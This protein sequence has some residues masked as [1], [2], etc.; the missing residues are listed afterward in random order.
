MKFKKDDLKLIVKDLV[1]ESLLE[2]LAEEYIEEATFRAMENASNQIVGTV[3]KQI[4]HQLAPIMEKINRGVQVQPST[5]RHSSQH[6]SLSS[7]SDNDYIETLDDDYDNVSVTESL[8]LS[9]GGD[10]DALERERLRIKAQIDSERQRAKQANLGST[11]GFDDDNDALEDL[12]TTAKT[13]KIDFGD[14]IRS[15]ANTLRE[16]RAAA[17]AGQG[18]YNI[19]DGLTANDSSIGNYIEKM[20]SSNK[21]KELLDKANAK[22]AQKKNMNSPIPTTSQMAAQQHHM[23]H[24]LSRKPDPQLDRPAH[25]VSNYAKPNN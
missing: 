9:L 12:G 3:T 8:G 13:D 11:I 1:R 15:S 14:M 10:M 6:A 23:Q 24:N 7:Y 19:S 16:Q 21:M 18:M 22:A 20:A 4:N 17:S 25:E 2:I 5:S